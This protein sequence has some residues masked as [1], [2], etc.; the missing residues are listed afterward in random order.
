MDSPDFAAKTVETLSD[1]SKEGL[2]AQLT[3]S[4]LAVRVNCS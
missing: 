3:G 2:L 1:P 4:P